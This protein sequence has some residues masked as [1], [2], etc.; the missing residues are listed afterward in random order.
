MRRGSPSGDISRDLP[1][2]AV[3][4]KEKIDRVMPRIDETMRGGMV[5]M[6]KNTVI[7]YAHKH[8]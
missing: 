6:E 2:I 3:D 7:R 5:T 8:R 1:A 4:T